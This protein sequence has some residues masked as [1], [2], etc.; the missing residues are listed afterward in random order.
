MSSH[1]VEQRHGRA[2]DARRR[3]RARRPGSPQPALQ[4][5]ST[6]VDLD[7]LPLLVD[8]HAAGLLRRPDLWRQQGPGRLE[9]HRLS[10][11]RL[12]E[13]C[14]S[15]AATRTLQYFAEGEAE[16][17]QR[18]STMALR[19]KPATDRRRASS[20]PARP[21]PPPPRCCREARRQGR[22]ARKRPVAHA[23]DL[24]RRRARQHQPL[25]SLARPAPQ[26]AHRGANTADE[27]PRVE[28]FCPVPQMVGGGTV[29]WQG[30]LPRFTANDFRMRTVAGDL[31][32]ASLADWPI[33]YDELEP[34]YRQGRMG[35][36]RLRAGRRQHVRSAPR[37]G[38]YPCPPHADVALCAEV[39]QGCA[40][41]WLELPSRP[42]RRPCRARSTAARRR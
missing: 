17:V 2:D 37:S 31:P 12:A 41:A 3:R 10:R 23:R 13:R 42:R 8:P 35:V 16:K 32:G 25:Q 22:G 14:P 1:A 30:W 15:P 39:H 27:A 29:H 18:S 26:P 33:T 20:A 38:G 5:T 24:R 34:Y 21:A 11:A 36:R 19:R 9:G 7:F 28:L 6:E 4:Q 40:R